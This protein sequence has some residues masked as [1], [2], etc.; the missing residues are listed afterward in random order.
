[1]FTVSNE[2]EFKSIYLYILSNIRGNI[3]HVN[4]SDGGLADFIRNVLRISGTTFL[5]CLVRKLEKNYYLFVLGRCMYVCVCVN[6]IT[7]LHG[8]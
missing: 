3:L 4:L 2:F 8:K 6:S 5:L 1:M 7:R